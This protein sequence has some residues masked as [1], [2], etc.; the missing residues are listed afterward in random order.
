MAAR[1]TKPKP[2]SYSKPKRSG[3]SVRQ[4]TSAKGKPKV[5]AGKKAAARASSRKGN[6]K[7]AVSKSAEEKR[8]EAKARAKEVEEYKKAEKRAGGYK[9]IRSHTAATKRADDR[10]DRSRRSKLRA[11][12][13]LDDAIT[14]E[15]RFKTGSTTERAVK[16]YLARK[17]RTKH[18]KTITKM[19]DANVS[20]GRA[21]GRLERDRKRRAEE[22]KKMG[23]AAS[24]PGRRK[25]T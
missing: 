2:R 4:V 13:A 21:V 5:A 17:A 18:S 3:P 7:V 8:A 11:D 6:A 12:K 23:R 16:A 25:K 22:A 10:L 9:H 20:K 19:L 14:K 24:R 1:H 15:V